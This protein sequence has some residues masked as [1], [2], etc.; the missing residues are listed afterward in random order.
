MLDVTEI[1]PKGRVTFNLLKLSGNELYRIAQRFNVSVKNIK[2]ITS[3]DPHDSPIILGAE[4]DE[5]VEDEKYFKI[6]IDSEFR[7][8]R[9][10]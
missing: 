3:L 6:L 7:N 9:C 5:K 1:D 2:L 10:Q 8:V 4:G